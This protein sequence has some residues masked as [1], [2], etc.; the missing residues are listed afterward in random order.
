VYKNYDPRA[1][2]IKRL[3]E[4]VFAVTTP[5]PLLPLGETTEKGLYVSCALTISGACALGGG[6]SAA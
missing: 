2:I 6:S 4:D 1:K 5:N 3:A